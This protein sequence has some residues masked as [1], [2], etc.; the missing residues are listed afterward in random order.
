MAQQLKR[1]NSVSPDRLDGAVQ[2]P[3]KV[4]SPIS[5]GA[6]DRAFVQNLLR[7]F[8]S[9]TPATESAAALGDA[10]RAISSWLAVE[11]LL[12]V[13]RSTA[14]A[15]RLLSQPAVMKSCAVPPETLERLRALYVSTFTQ[16]AS[17]PKLFR[18]LL[19]DFRKNGVPILFIKGLVI[20]TWLYDDPVLREHDD[21][22]L[23]IPMDRA[24]DAHAL[25][26]DMG[27][28]GAY[29][30][31]LY[32]GEAP[33]TADY[34][35]GPN[36]LQVDLSFDPL[37]IFWPAETERDPFSGWLARQQTVSIAGCPI[38]TLG[39]EDQFVH[40]A[41]HLQFHD[42]FRA[43]WFVDMLLLLRRYG[44]QLDWP[45]IGDIA[46]E[47]GL[48]GGLYRTLEMAELLY[49]AEI[50][51]AAWRELRPNTVVRYLH[52]TIWPETIAVPHDG[53][54]SGGSP[55]GPRFI[56]PRGIHPFAGMILLGFDRNR[57]RHAQYLFRRVL[58]P[59]SW[60][61][62]TYA[63]SGEDDRS[64]ASLLLRHWRELRN[65]RRSVRRRHVSRF[66]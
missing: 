51:P 23:L 7:A 50:P 32:Y 36:E 22:D 16:V 24:A 63:A 43:N 2:E 57:A 17:E 18:L 61:R 11:R 45:L 13:H 25:L 3:P 54:R 60:L 41:R 40:L 47:Y 31:P 5:S 19:D 65:L 30:P 33:A 44:S 20:G 12:Q 48:Q 14:I 39:P 29:R 46:R 6:G 64:Y 34:V 4:A 52:R 1:A 37:R 26:T 15:Y 55:I 53:P 56:S 21:V 10:A 38:P 59:K 27:Y 58:P 35:R 9:T 8:V 28:A 49:D 66:R 42:F 62:T